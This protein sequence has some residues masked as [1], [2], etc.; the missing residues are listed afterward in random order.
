[1][2]FSLMELVQFD[3]LKPM[4]LIFTFQ[5]LCSAPH[6]IALSLAADSKEMQNDQSS[7]PGVM[8][9]NAQGSPIWTRHPMYERAEVSVILLLHP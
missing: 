6:Y 5:W 1:M 3:G 4:Y 8:R 2:G 9:A 7:P